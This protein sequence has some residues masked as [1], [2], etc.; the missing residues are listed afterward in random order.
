MSSPYCKRLK[1][2]KNG[3]KFDVSETLFIIRKTNKKDEF[4]PLE[5][6]YTFHLGRLLVDK[7]KKAIEEEEELNSSIDSD[8]L[9]RS[10]DAIDE[11]RLTQVL[12]C[13][14]LSSHYQMLTFPDELAVET[15]IEYFFSHWPKVRQRL[16]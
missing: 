3:K 5:R 15:Q 9:S 2:Q 7:S 11:E 13:Y 4:V 1:Y 10:Q 6:K 8:S 14:F 16:H 12:A